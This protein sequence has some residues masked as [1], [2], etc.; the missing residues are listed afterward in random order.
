MVDTHTL[1]PHTLQLLQRVAQFFVDKQ[2]PAILVG[3][4]VRNLLLN[5]PN[6]DWD[7][8]T[9]PSFSQLARQLANKLGGYYVHLHEKAARVIVKN[10]AQET[11]FDLAPLRG[12][13]I[14]E[15]LN[16]R[17]FTLNAIALPLSTL[18][19]HLTTNAPLALIDPLHG[20][21]DLQARLLRAVN[22][23]VFVDDPPRMLRALRFAR[24]YQ[25]AIEP[26]TTRLIKRDSSLLLKSAPDRI[27]TELYTMLE[28][29]GAT[30]YLYSLDEYG[31]LTILMPEL[32]PAR[33]MHQPGLHHWD[34]FEHSLETVA[35]LELLAHTLVNNPSPLPP[36][37][38]GYD[39][40]N[41][42]PLIH[43]LLQEA[44]Q[45]GIFQFASLFKPVM[46]MAAL[47]HDIGKPVTYTVDEEG[48]IRFYGHPQ[49]GV[50]LA[51][52]ILQ[53][54]HSSTQERRLVQQVVA[55]HMRP[56]Q[57]SGTIVTPRAI[58]RY[59]V[60][61]G[62]AGIP[63]ALVSLADHLS[64]RGPLPLT[65]HWEHHLATVRLLLTSYIRERSRF[66]P[67][68]LI[69]S[70]ELMQRLHIS[71]GPVMG[72]LLEQIAEAQAEGRVTSKDDALWLAEELLKKRQEPP[73]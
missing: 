73:L 64:M 40:H 4:A 15:D 65:E 21:A 25:L 35:S 63:V 68:R 6:N 37:F 53:R 67:P 57:L 2:Q 60:D 72:Y 41:D 45:Q 59:F 28:L 11:I 58:R 71:P 49:A 1:A 47:L 34:V 54:I 33:G 61:L 17:D 42:L 46:K 20:E 39:P 43:T 9:G 66:L 44:E 14:T 50:P 69:Q 13:S 19:D 7:I 31:L 51:Q 5:T 29:D 32:T 27:R 30:S 18:I 23:G 8:A 22:D 70:E 26:H 56:G 10:D 55:N 52:D 12:S 36:P 24:H 48:H 3:G 38:A 16:Q 62:P